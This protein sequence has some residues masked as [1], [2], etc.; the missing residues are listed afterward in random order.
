VMN[1]DEIYQSIYTRISERGE[2]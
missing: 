2:V 1:D